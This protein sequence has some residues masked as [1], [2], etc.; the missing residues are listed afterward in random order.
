[1]SEPELRSER[2]NAQRGESVRAFV[3][4]WALEEYGPDH[5]EAW[6]FILSD[7]VTNL[8]HLNDLLDPGDCTYSL[9]SELLYR[10]HRDYDIERQEEQEEI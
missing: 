9:T 1:M 5:G 3:E 8:L 2:T 4:A 6:P 10:V 7:L